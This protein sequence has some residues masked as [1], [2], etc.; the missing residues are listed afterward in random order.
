MSPSPRS[1]EP[2]KPERR[3]CAVLEDLVADGVAAFLA[4]T[5]ELSDHPADDQ[6]NELREESIAQLDQLVRL[7]NG[8]CSSQTTRRR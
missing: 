1:A 6:L 4:V 5:D 7:R 8:L 2:E 3:A